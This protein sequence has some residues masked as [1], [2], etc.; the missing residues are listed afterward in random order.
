GRPYP[1]R[2]AGV[3]LVLARGPQ[4][5]RQVPSV[6]QLRAGV[7][8]LADPGA[9]RRPRRDVADELDRAQ[10]RLQLLTLAEEV[11]EDPRVVGRVC[12]AKR[13]AAAARRSDI[14]EPSTERGGAGLA[15]A[16]LPVVD[17]AEHDLEV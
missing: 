5:L 2:A 10:H 12:R 1:A 13:D 4:P 17:R 6:A 15:E 3:V 7:E 14:A 8:L 16:V 9:E 11:A